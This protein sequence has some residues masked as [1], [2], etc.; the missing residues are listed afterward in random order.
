[1]FVETAAALTLMAAGATEAWAAFQLMTFQF[2]DA[3]AAHQAAKDLWGSAG[4]LQQ[5][6]KGYLDLAMSV[7]K[8]DAVIKS[9]TPGARGFSTA[10]K[11]S[12]TAADSAA[13]G[14]TKIKTAAD[15]IPKDV[16]VTVTTTYIERRVN[17]TTGKPASGAEEGAYSVPNEGPGGTSFGNWGGAY[18]NA[19]K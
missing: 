13:A 3:A 2:K 16:K 17:E 10:M 9:A 7:G 8:A 5:Q 19:M 18:G 1:V 4:E 12:A 14:M 6:A 15:A 11:E